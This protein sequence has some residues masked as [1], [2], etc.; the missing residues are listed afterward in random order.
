[1]IH[2]ASSFT[3]KI[4][5]KIESRVTMEPSRLIGKS[6]V[7][8]SQKLQIYQRQS[9]K[10]RQLFF[11]NLAVVYS[12]DDEEEEKYEED[13]YCSIDDAEY[14]L[15]E[16]C[17]PDRLTINQD[18]IAP[19]ARLAVAFSPPESGLKLEDIENIEVLSMDENHIELSAVVCDGESCVTLFVP[20]S[21]PHV[22]EKGNDGRTIEECILDNINELDTE[23]G[24][25]I[26]ENKLNAEEDMKKDQDFLHLSSNNIRRVVDLPSWWIAP[27]DLYNEC[28]IIRQLLNDEEYNFEINALA[29]RGL[30][31]LGNSND[32]S[33]E[34]A[35]VAA[36]GPAGFCFK[37][38]VK[39][40]ENQNNRDDKEIDV[41]IPYKFGVESID[42]FQSLKAAV[43]GSVA[44]VGNFV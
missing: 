36:V 38:D 21:F 9:L 5:G 34:K 28:E 20:I 30:E 19:L 16:E 40:K 6:F 3:G 23:A 26:S 24:K 4:S 29:S 15:Y 25:I 14:D 31:Y 1:M 44:E 17:L 22:C 2:T 18:K 8:S 39:K 41:Y 42:D 12:W 32:F 13:V 33:L 35:S 37:A 7:S 43:L 27:G 10:R 11:Q